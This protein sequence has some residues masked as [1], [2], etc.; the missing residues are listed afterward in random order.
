[1]G[2]I[3][4]IICIFIA[5]FAVV[6]LYLTRSNIIDLLDRDVVMYDQNYALKKSS[7]EEAFNCL[8]AISQNGTEL[9]NNQQFVARAKQAY[10]GLLCTL[11]SA[12]LYQEFYRMTI[13]TT[14]NDYSIEDIEAFKIACR[15]ELISKC[16]RKTEQFKGATRGNLKSGTNQSA[17]RTTPYDTQ[18]NSQLKSRVKQVSKPNQDD[19]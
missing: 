19:D 7:I 8:D 15:M 10:N 18:L 2:V 14:D 1:M 4:I 12:R 9:K 5:M 13:D 6:I 11:T 17:Q 3:S 16:K